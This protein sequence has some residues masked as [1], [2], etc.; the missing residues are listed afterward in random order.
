MRVY[1]HCRAACWVT[2]YT[3]YLVT[4][5]DTRIGRVMP[6]TVLL[7]LSGCVCILF[8]TLCFPSPGHPRSLEQNNA[9]CKWSQ[10]IVSC[11]KVIG[12]PVELLSGACLEPDGATCSVEHSH[13]CCQESSPYISAY[14]V[15]TPPN[16]NA[17][18]SDCTSKGDDC[19]DKG[20]KCGDGEI[21][22]S[23][24]KVLCGVKEPPTAPSNNSPAN[25]WWAYLVGVLGLLVVGGGITCSL[26]ITCYWC[27]NSCLCCN[28]YLGV[29]GNNDY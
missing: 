23:G 19:L 28:G 27:Y 22:E 29:P 6:Q 16:C 17:S 2:N 13:Y 26:A 18:C 25:Y 15:G 10:C 14:W 5:R 21:C 11:S 20:N 9:V 4:R 8:L 12:Y 3:V 7:R 24:V 1:I